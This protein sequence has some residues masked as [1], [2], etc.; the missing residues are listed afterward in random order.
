MSADVEYSQGKNVTGNSKAMGVSHLIFSSLQHATEE[1]KRR[2]IN[3]PNFD[4][5]A[6]V[7]KYILALG[8]GCSFVIPGY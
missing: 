7:E 8:V 5:K 3:V 2:L 4:S 6:R 1:T